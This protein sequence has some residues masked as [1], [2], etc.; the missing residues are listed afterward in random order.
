MPTI[1]P[2]DALIRAADYLTDAISV[3]LPTHTVTADAVDQLMEIYKQQARDWIDAGTAQRVLREHAQAE[4]VNNEQAQPV[5]A[6]PAVR[7]RRQHP[8]L[9]YPKHDSTNHTGR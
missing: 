1:T 5:T 7:G 4:S 2:A 8:R 3:L 9:P 6:F